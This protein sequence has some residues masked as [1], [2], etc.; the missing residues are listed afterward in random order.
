MRGL[1]EAEAAISEQELSPWL[2]KV[3]ET[4]FMFFLQFSSEIMTDGHTRQISSRSN[5]LLLEIL[6]FSVYYEACYRLR[7][8]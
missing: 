2:M 5:A 8:T 1:R 6:L 4:V 3:I 7:L